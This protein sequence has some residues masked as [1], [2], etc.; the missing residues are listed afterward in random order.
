MGFEGLMFRNAKGLYD[1]GQRSADLLKMKDFF[2]DEFEVIDFYEGEGR[3]AGCVMWR[4]KTK[5]GKVF[6]CRPEGTHEERAEFLKEAKDYVGKML[7][8]RYQELTK[9]GLPRFPVGVAF[10]DY[11]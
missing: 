4:C 11:E 9:D 10:R 2:D 6:G 7:T 1:V 8:I 3:E 5:D